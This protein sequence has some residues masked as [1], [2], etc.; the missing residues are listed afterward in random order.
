M[1]KTN[2]VRLIGNFGGNLKL[3]Q[4]GNGVNVATVSMGTHEVYKDA[5][6]QKV[7]KTD[8]HNIVFFGKL[9]DLVHKFTEKGSKIMIEGKIQT[10]QYVDKDGVN[11]YVTEIIA[12]EVLF[13]DTKKE[14]V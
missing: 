12:E 6:G 5:N 10:R 2:Q 13:L 4:S 8:W 9:A 7:S 14:S 11:R 3:I 1:S